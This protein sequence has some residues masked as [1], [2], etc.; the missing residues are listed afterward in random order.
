MIGKIIDKFL[1]WGTVTFFF[2]WMV[3]NYGLEA[4]AEGIR[5]FGQT[6]DRQKKVMDEIKRMQKIKV[7]DGGKQ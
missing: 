7:H 6:C 3:K 2:M 1:M 5:D 4:S